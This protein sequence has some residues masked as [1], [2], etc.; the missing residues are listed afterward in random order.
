[1]NVVSKVDNSFF[2]VIPLLG[3]ADSSGRTDYVSITNDPSTVV[4]WNVGDLTTMAALG[5]KQ[6][7]SNN[8]HP[9]QAVTISHS[10]KGPDSYFYVW[11]R[12]IPW[13]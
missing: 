13:P 4:A 2:I 1:M 6:P 8:P 3:N 10:G 9:F 11:M 12:A 7:V 5:H